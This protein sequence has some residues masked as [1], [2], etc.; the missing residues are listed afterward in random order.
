MIPENPPESASPPA[1]VDKAAVRRM[2]SGPLRESAWTAPDGQRIRRIDGVAKAVPARGSLLFLPGRGDCYEKYLE[3]LAGWQDAGWQVTS[4]DWRWQAGSGRA[5]LGDAIGHVDDFARWIDDLATFWREWRAATPGPHGLIGHSMGGHL[6]LRALAEHRVDPDAA[7]LVAP[8]LG[9]QGMGL[10]TAVLLAAARLMAALGDPRRAAWQDSEKPGFAPKLRMTLLTHDAG[11]YADDEFWR[12]ARPEL[13]MGPASW[14]WLRAA[15]ASIHGLEAPGVLET[16]TVPVLLLGT[17][18]D[19]LVRWPAIARAAARLPH[20]ELLAFGREAR[21]EILRESDPVRDR[22][23][24]AI[25]DFLDRVAPARHP[26][27]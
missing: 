10:P 2:L 25:D 19:G 3:T 5:G 12:A 21:H 17:R 14:G 23:L 7:V 1:V 22:A 6:V 20:A 11:R 8:M 24:A 4:L 15:L 16:V 26:P 13:A 18:H 27:V 9:L